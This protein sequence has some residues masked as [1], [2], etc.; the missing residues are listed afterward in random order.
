MYSN[1]Y[2]KSYFYLPDELEKQILT[3]GVRAGYKLSS[4]SETV[5]GR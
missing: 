4:R 3:G 2:K 5:S 1:S